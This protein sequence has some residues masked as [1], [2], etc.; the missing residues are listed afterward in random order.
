MFT[1][2]SVGPPLVASTMGWKASVAI[3]AATVSPAMAPSSQRLL[4][5]VSVRERAS[6][7][8]EV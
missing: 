2:I 8:S 5:K 1:A 6:S 3:S 4:R 7:R